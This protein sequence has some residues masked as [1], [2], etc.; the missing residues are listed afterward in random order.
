MRIIEEVAP[1]IFKIRIPLPMPFLDSMNAYVIIGPDRALLVDT[2]MY[3]PECMGVMQRALAKLGV[4]LERTDFFLTHHHGDHFGLLT[5]LLSEGSLVYVSEAEAGMVQ[6]M[7]NGEILEDTANF[8]CLTGFPEHDLQRIIPEDLRAAYSTRDVRSFHFVKDGDAIEIGSY[9]FTCLCTPGHSV[10]HTCLY[11]PDARIFFSGDHILKDITPGIQL[12]SDDDNPL[13]HYVD[14]LERL[15]S[16][17]IEIMLPGHGGIIRECRQRI[18][19]LKE[20]HRRRSLDVRRALIDNGSTAYGVASR[21][22]WS[23]IDGEGWDGLPLVHQ[24]FATG[25]AFS[26]LKFL[27][28]KGQ[29]RKRRDGKILLYTLADS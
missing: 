16:L 24:F 19:G 20:H 4:D 10:G 12:R 14:S 3:R 7:R 1:K 8:V 6:R 27:E 23:A 15:G 11:D 25:E 26:L 18:E 13:Q 28:E 29:V 9:R 22:R 5:D 17:D 2:G 21:V